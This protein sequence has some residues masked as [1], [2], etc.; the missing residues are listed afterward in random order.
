MRDCTDQDYETIVGEI[1]SL[2]N[3]IIDSAKYL[4]CFEDLSSLNFFGSWNTAVGSAI[5]I[6]VR[7]CQEQD[8]ASEQEIHEYM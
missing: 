2:E 3:A 7:R 8:C 4:R 6:E 1:D 5:M